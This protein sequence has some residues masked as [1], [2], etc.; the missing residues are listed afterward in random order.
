MSVEN[1]KAFLEK[2]S[3]DETF[4]GQLAAAGDSDARLAVARQAGYD[5]TVEEFDT[6]VAKLEAAAD[7]LSEDDL[8]SV[9]GGMG[10]MFRNDIPIKWVRPTSG[11]LKWENFV[12]K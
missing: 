1:V 12:L 2:A 3:N 7:E 10:S 9:A 4:R 11:N 5:F 6:T 8:E